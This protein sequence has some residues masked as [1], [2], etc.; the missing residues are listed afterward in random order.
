MVQAQGGMGDLVKMVP[1]KMKGTWWNVDEGDPTPC[2]A[3]PGS[4]PLSLEY[5]GTASHMGRSTGAVTNCF[6]PG[7][8]GSRPFLAQSGTTRAANG[9]LLYAYGTASGGTAMIIHA[10]LSFEIGPV[11]L[12]GGKGRFANAEGWYHL[13]GDNIAGGDFTYVG[14]ISSV[15]S[16]K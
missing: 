12:V 7:T 3:F 2:E 8:P 11:P 15:G 6:G 16:S 9:D 10:D 14:E 5:E 4:V 1:F 13:Y